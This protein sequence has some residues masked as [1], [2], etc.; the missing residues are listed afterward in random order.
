MSPLIR[1]FLNTLIIKDKLY[2]TTSRCGT[3]SV[4]KRVDV[5]RLKQTA[6]DFTVIFT[7]DKNGFYIN[8][9]K[10][11]ADAPAMTTAHIGT[12]QHWRIVNSS[13]ELHPFPIIRSR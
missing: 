2:I 13:A 11:S 9:A 8:G 4:Y 1:R 3:P 5:E 7:E 6:P 10:F 12:Y